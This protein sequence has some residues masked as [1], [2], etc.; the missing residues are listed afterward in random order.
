[1]VSKKKRVKYQSATD[2][3]LI[4]VKLLKLANHHNISQL[5][6]LMDMYILSSTPQYAHRSGSEFAWFSFPVFSTCTCKT[7]NTQHWRNIACISRA[8]IKL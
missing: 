4:N 8:R 5:L 7:C 6:V 1:M 2:N 3:K